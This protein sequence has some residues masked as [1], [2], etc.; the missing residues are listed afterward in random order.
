MTKRQQCVAATALMFALAF[1][2]LAY[3]IPDAFRMPIVKKHEKGDPPEASVFSHGE[4]NAYYCYSCHPTLFPQAKV[5][6]TH[7][8][9]DAG[10]YCGACHNGRTAWSIKDADVECET[11]HREDNP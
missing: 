10:K 11:C 6:F 3:A 1:P 2:W 9:M 5:G 4:H 7:D 8:E